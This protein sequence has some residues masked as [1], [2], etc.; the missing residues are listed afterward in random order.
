MGKPVFTSPQ[1]SRIS[2]ICDNAG[3]VFL[4]ITVLSPIIGGIDRTDWSVIIVGT[5][6]TTVL[7]TSSVLLARKGLP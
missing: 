1:F 2:N 3:N 7:W 5:A 4:A 6:L